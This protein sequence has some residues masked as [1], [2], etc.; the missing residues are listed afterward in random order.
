M[1]SEYLVLGVQVEWSYFMI[2]YDACFVF[3]DINN[4]SPHSLS[5][6]TLPFSKYSY[7]FCVPHK[8]E[9]KLIEL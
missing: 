5:L 3:L 6:F 8:E 1:V 4:P 7:L 2:F 9:H